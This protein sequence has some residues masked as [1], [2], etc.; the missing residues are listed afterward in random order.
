MHL[1]RNLIPHS[2]EQRCVFAI[3]TIRV[4]IR[5]LLEFTILDS[6]NSPS[7]SLLGFLEEDLVLFEATTTRF[8]LVEVSPYT[9]E[10]VREAEY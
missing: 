9:S 6:T 8:G 5:H 2:S 10:H 4:T 1:S 3:F 7:A